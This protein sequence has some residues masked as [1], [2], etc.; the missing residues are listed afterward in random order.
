MTLQ[1]EV[2]KLRREARDLRQTMARAERSR[3]AA[4]GREETLKNQI[5]NLEDTV[6]PLEDENT[7][8]KEHVGNLEEQV[9]DLEARLAAV[10]LHKDKLS[11]MLFKTNNTKKVFTQDT[12]TAK[13]SIGAQSG[14]AGHGRKV[15]V[16]VDEDVAVWLSC[17]PK[18]TAPVSQSNASYERI[19]EDIALPIKSRIK[20]YAIQRQW[21]VR[22]KKEVHGVPRDTLPG[23]RFGTNILS[24]ILFAK[25]RLRLPAAKIKESLAVQ[26]G[27]KIREG[28]I[29]H[30]L[31]T[32][33]SKF[34]FQYQKII[35]EIRQ[36]PHKHADETGWRTNGKNGWCWAFLTP[37]A[38][39]YTIEET[40]GGGVPDVM[41]GKTP[42]GVL[43]RD[44]YVGYTHLPMEQ[45]SCWAHLLR[46]SRDAAKQP[47]AKDEIRTLHTELTR[48]YGDLSVI[49]SN[50]FDQSVRERAYAKFTKKIATITK[51]S[52]MT[53]DAQKIQTRMKNQGTNLITA[54]LHENVPLTNNLAERQ[55]RPVAVMRKISGGSRSTH[56]AMAQ[57][58]NMSIVQT[59]FL[60]GQ[61]LLEQ[62]KELLAPKDLKFSLERSE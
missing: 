36:S 22:C 51:R 8:L 19:V 35:E 34:H 55:M 45:Q 26:Y 41:L 60:K 44:D 6:G 40:R 56:G 9:A 59:I 48:M 3:A 11:G 31:Q 25:Y 39:A 18:C 58:V 1:E 43:V 32:M 20:R 5:K 2:E 21:C 50:P 4:I 57:A 37:N 61:P 46:N 49:I 54:L 53:V 16:R 47:F 30:I 42:R 17:C 27:V 52:Y 14:H 29:A 62:L 7:S 28:T 10:T 38:V 24:F 12:A 23:F 33:G 15:P 13:R